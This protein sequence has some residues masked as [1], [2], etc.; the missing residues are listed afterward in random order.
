MK[1]QK[2]IRP[3]ARLKLAVRQHGWQR[4]NGSRPYR[5]GNFLFCDYHYAFRLK[6]GGNAGKKLAP[7]SGAGFC[8][9]QAEPQKFFPE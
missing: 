3:I 1:N 6:L 5:D 7:I 4:G 2:G 9:D 8:F